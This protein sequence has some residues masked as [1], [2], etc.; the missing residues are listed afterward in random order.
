MLG[1]YCTTTQQTT[2]AATVAHVTRA[3]GGCFHLHT[4]SVLNI[5]TRKLH[6]NFLFP[7]TFR[8]LNTHTH[9]RKH[10]HSGRARPDCCGWRYVVES[11]ITR[12]SLWS[13]QVCPGVSR[14]QCQPSEDGPSLVGGREGYAGAFS[15][16]PEA[17]Q[18]RGRWMDGRWLG[19]GC[20][21]ARPTGTQLPLL[22]DS[23]VL[24]STLQRN[25]KQL[26]GRR[27]HCSSRICSLQTPPSKK[28]LAFCPNILY[29]RV[30]ALDD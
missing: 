12:A 13:N 29:G 16:H 2:G 17:Y 3:S 26:E 22:T 18:S 6:K 23:S 21:F 30:M 7:V 25:E 15:R 1:K 5:L 28:R 20:G 4:N 9:A 8:Q 11:S 24:Q 27:A 10:S 14:T 19:R